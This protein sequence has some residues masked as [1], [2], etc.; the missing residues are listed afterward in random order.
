MTIIDSIGYIAACLTTISFIPQVLLVFK[1]KDTSSISLGM[2]SI[3]T[4]GITCWLIYG[5]ALRDIPIT[6][7]NT[8]TL[9]LAST[10]LGYKIYHTIKSH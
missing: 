7:A 1:T 8:I 5:I 3:F 2:Y 9:L 4:L 10:I 6:V